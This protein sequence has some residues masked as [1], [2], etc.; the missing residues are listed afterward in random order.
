MSPT[1]KAESLKAVVTKAMIMAVNDAAG[2]L[3]DRIDG[4]DGMADDNREFAL[5]ERRLKR[6]LRGFV[7]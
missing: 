4:Q 5:A 6:F 2:G 7:P 1:P 3:N